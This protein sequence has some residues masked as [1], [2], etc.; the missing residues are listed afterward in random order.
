MNTKNNIVGVRLDD[1]TLT[2]LDELALEFGTNRSTFL[3]W[4]LAYIDDRKYPCGRLRAF[5]Q[6]RARMEKIS[7]EFGI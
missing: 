3:R 2:R 1:V 6:H 4:L 5:R 7:H